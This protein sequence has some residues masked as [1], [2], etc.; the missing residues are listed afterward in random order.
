MRQGLRYTLL[1]IP[2]ILHSLS[3]PASAQWSADVRLTFN[4]ALSWLHYNNSWNIAADDSFVVHTVWQD[5]RTTYAQIFYKRSTDGG[6]T[7]SVDTDLSNRPQGCGGSSIAISGTTVHLV[8]ESNTDVFDSQIF[9]KRSTNS[10]MTWSANVQLTSSAG[11]SSWPSLAVSGPDIHVAWHDERDGNP[12]IYYKRSTDGGTTWGPD[13][14]Q[15]INGFNSRYPSV[16]AQG[17]SVH[18]V[19]ED[20]N[21]EVAYMRSSNSGAS[22]SSDTALTN[23]AAI[24]SSPSVSVSSSIVHVTWTDGPDNP[25]EIF[26]KRSTNAGLTWSADTRLTNNAAPKGYPNITALDQNV[27]IVWQDE[28]NASGNFEIYYKNSTDGGVTFS[29]DTRLTTAAGNSA[30]ASTANNGTYVYLTWMDSRGRER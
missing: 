9:Y 28:R 18:I 27:H 21:G 20:Y 3:Q 24:S 13:V 12:E 30:F 15:T 5:F 6:V 26:Y 19:W 16:S 29:A 4:T 17:S 23:T 14:R 8:F 1:L 11:V 7:W 22:W 25:F 2:L 10:G